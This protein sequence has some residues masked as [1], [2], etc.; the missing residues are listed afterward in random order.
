MIKIYVSKNQFKKFKISM[1]NCDDYNLL[2]I[3]G[4][5]SFE[6]EYR[7]ETFMKELDQMNI[8]YTVRRQR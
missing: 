7:A 5:V 2:D 3:C 1:E 4:H 6:R 8:F